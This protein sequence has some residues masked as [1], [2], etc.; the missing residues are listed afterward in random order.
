MSKVISQNEP[1]MSQILPTVKCSDCGRQVELRKLAI[2]LCS[3]VPPVPSLP[4]ATSRAATSTNLSSIDSRADYRPNS[5]YADPYPQKNTY[6]AYGSYNTAPTMERR[7]EAY[8]TPD[9]AHPHDVQ[10]APRTPRKPVANDYFHGPEYAGSTKLPTREDQTRDY[11][12]VRKNSTSP[13]PAH[14]QVPK[15]DPEQTRSPNYSNPYQPRVNDNYRKNEESSHETK[16][17]FEDEQY[18]DIFHPSNDRGDALDNLMSDLMAKM[19]TEERK[20]PTRTPLPPVQKALS[21]SCSACGKGISRSDE[22]VNMDSRCYHRKCFHCA[23]CAVDFSDRHA[24]YEHEGKLFCERDYR[25]VK[26]RVYCAGCDKP[27]TALQ[28]S[29]QALGKHYH[30][31]HL[32][33]YHC[34]QP[35]I[36]KTTGMVEHQGRVFCREDFK[37]L[38]LPKCRSCGLPVEKEAVSALDGKLQGKWHRNCFGCQTCH[39]PFPDNTFYVYDGAPY[40]KRHYHRLN[41]SLCRSCDEPIEGACVQTIEGWR[42][43]PVCLSCSVCRHPI[44]DVYYIHDNRTYCETHM[45]QLQRQR[46]VRGERRQTMFKNL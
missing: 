27:L 25:V 17:W 13:S 20:S 10:S 31:G 41:N 46:N 34:R 37:H 23:L 36:P 4:N 8:L 14:H 33:C 32:Q 39:N 6:D 7:P 19:N 44:T 38:F 2:H 9:R 22:I 26:K 35:I 16:G 42:Y 40:C 15:Y 1:R 43:H 12:S 30:A 3:S 29:V 28:E 45:L 21:A 24:C 18:D 11:N 5:P